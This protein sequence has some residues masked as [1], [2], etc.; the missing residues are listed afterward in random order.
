MSARPAAKLVDFGDRMSQRNL[1]D[2]AIQDGISISSI[3]KRILD[4]LHI[5][6]P[7]DGEGQSGARSARLL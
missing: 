6:A 4:M 7:L 1:T 3:D 5:L 2:V